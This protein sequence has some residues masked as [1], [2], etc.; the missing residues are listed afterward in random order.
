METFLKRDVRSTV[1]VVALATMGASIAYLLIANTD[2]KTFLGMAINAFVCL[3]TV[4]SVGI[5]I[6]KQRKREQEQKH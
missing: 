3:C 5:G 1:F 6:S 2:E 4:I